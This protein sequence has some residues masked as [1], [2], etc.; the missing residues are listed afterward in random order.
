MSETLKEKIVTLVRTT[1][2]I[3]KKTI[4]ESTATKGIVLE[5]AIARLVKDRILKIQN[6]EGQKYYFL[7]DKD[8][9][10]SVAGRGEGTEI[11]EPDS[12]PEKKGSL[13]SKKGKAIAKTSDEMEEKEKPRTKKGKSEGGRDMRK[14]KFDGKL[15]TK[16]GLVLAVVQKYVE[17]RKN[18][19][20]AKLK[21]AFPDEL[22][23]RFGVFQEVRKAKTFT[24]GGRDRF[25][26][27][28][29]R[30]IK[31]QNSKI[32]VS[33]QWSAD[34]IKPFLSTAKKLGFEIR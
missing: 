31:I 17:K 15:H 27:Q 20:L 21:E 9:E 16:G 18:I 33:N 6:R 32:A 25:F 11:N 3:D 14:F 2:G 34:N 19:S 23:Q 4:S 1:E 24:S 28:D 8:S 7:A 12:E 30:L 10:T 5:G 13:K 29:D 26:L 22:L